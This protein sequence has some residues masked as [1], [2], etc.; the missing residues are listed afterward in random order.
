[1]LRRREGRARR[2][3][4]VQSFN[5]LIPNILTVGALCAGLTA[6]RFALDERFQ[7][8][9]L[10]IVLAAVLDGLDGRVARL[11]GATSRFGAELDSLSDFVCFGVAPALMLY[12]WSFVGGGRFGWAMVLLFAVCAALRLARFNT[13]A[14]DPDRPAW[15]GNYF[16]GV[17]APAGAGLALLPMIAHFEWDAALFRDPNLVATWLAVVAG[18]M[19]SRI[20]TFAVKRLRVPNRL[21]LPVLALVG[22]VVAGLAA[23]PWMTLVLVGLAYAGSIPWSIAAVRRHRRPAMPEAAID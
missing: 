22:S 15:A 2:R 18:L 1:M 21:V 10:A 16:T 17:P 11:I 5:R 8:A 14:D 23:E 7:L 19:V 6:I 20:P 12:L 4:R 9:V 13:T 3:L